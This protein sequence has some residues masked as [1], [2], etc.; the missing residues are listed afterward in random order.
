MTDIA[1]HIADGEP[2][3]LPAGAP[4]KEA[5]DK[6][7]SGKQRK[8]TIAAHANGVAVD[9]SRP[10]YDNTE[11]T[12]IQ[13]D[14]PEALDILR[15]STSH[16]M[17]E[18]VRDLFGPGVKVA[19][20]PAIENGFYYDF[21]RD[22][23]FSPEDFVAIEK[24]MEEIA[25]QALPF[26]RQEKPRQ[27]LIERFRDQGEK[28][29]VELLEEIPDD[30]VSIYR[31]GDFVD[32]CRGPHL[33][34]TSW[35]KHF[36]LLRVAGAYWRGDEKNDVLQRIYGTVFFDAKELKKYLNDLEEAKK[37]DHRRL[38]KELHLFTVNDQIGPGLIL[39]QPKGAQLRR[40]IEDYWKD[41]H[42]RHGY[43]LLYTPHIARQDLWKTSGHLDFYAENMYAG[44]EI[45]E[46]K[47]QLK[48]MNCPFH[49]GV[50]KSDKRSYREFPIRWAELG[51]VY[52]YERAG[53]LHGLLRV[54]GFTQDDA[55]IFCREDQLEE[56]IFNILD[57]NLHILKT[58]GFADYDIYLSTRPEKSVGSDEIWEQA[59][60]AL[61]HALEKKGLGYTV[62]PGEGVFYGP[63]IDIKIK[64][65][66]GRSW[67][68]STIQVD[69]NLPE[70]FDMTYTGTDN[71]D[72]R[73]IMIHR[74]LM[75]SLERFVGVLI[76]HYAGV[77]P[78]WFA[79]VQARILNITDDQADYCE[80][81][82]QELRKAGVRIEKDLRNEKLNY[83]IREAQ[84]GKIPYML[85]VGDQE[86]A[87]GTVTVRL[88]DGKNLPPMTIAD[89]A[90]KV[91]DECRAG[92]GI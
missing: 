91:A 90:A 92:R 63:K 65:Q 44:M 9:L 73:P 57:L 62:D 31:Q 4:V 11:L 48:P 49:I 76:E 40:L 67:Q 82:Y 88:R 25:A 8:R 60:K 77:F 5:L 58:F 13:I 24:R 28:Y 75:G 32:L 29:K 42:Y 52:R 61:K 35:V 79:P 43:E 21:R 18:A 84:I 26:T 36:K 50:Y 80:R 69:F 16:V 39:W 1:V 23:P 19:I 83:K 3:R 68:C 34:D 12:P 85:I 14:S 27:E 55:H 33:P 71:H 59:T 78:L 56:E 51:T 41:E 6:L 7:L 15:H 47:Y 20:G 54:R 30:T 46:V 72:H 87:D 81:V 45:D 53:A 74:A 66:L 10:L 86:K 22:E 89:F 70:R 2:I 37:R 38:G 17:A 64:D